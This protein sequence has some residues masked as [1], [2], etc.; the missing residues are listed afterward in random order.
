[1]G[2]K[3]KFGVPHLCLGP[4]LTDFIITADIVLHIDKFISVL[5]LAKMKEEHRNKYTANFE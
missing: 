2:V 5:L 3:I 4:S 1:M